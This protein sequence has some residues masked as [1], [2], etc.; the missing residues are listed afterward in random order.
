[1]EKQPQNDDFFQCKLVAESCHIADKM[2]NRQILI[3]LIQPDLALDSVLKY[4][5]T[6]VLCHYGQKK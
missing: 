3:S 1:M 2:A 4:F 5:C 6:N